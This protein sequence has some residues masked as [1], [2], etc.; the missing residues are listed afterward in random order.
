M[1][2]YKNKFSEELDQ[3]AEN[4]SRMKGQHVR[5]AMMRAMNRTAI[6]VRQD[7]ARI[8]ANKHKIPVIRVRNTMP[9]QEAKF[10]DLRARLIE[11]HAPLP[12]IALLRKTRGNDKGG[13]NHKAYKADRYKKGRKGL[14]KISLKLSKTVNRGFVLDKA[15]IATNKHGQTHIFRRINRHKMAGAYGDPNKKNK[16]YVPKIPFHKDLEK[17]IPK[18]MRFHTSIFY[19]KTLRHE[20][21]YR[22]KKIAK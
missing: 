7:T 16:V 8:V 2:K 4:L 18:I 21:E 19:L 3:M 17:T 1:A 22:W 5:K 14:F 11:S 6:K 13:I 9:I 12:L 10:K 15:F 20:Y